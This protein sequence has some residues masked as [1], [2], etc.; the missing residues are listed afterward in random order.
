[1]RKRPVEHAASAAPRHPIRRTH[2]RTLAVAETPPQRTPQQSD[3]PF[4]TTL[5]PRWLFQMPTAERRRTQLSEMQVELYR[6][7]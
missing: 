4:F 5:R 6:G 7:H 2:R 1:V 3:T